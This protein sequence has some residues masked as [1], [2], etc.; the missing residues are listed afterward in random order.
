[1]LVEYMSKLREW[2]RKEADGQWVLR[3]RIPSRFVL[4]TTAQAI[5]LWRSIVLII[6]AFDLYSSGEFIGLFS[7]FPVLYSRISLFLRDNSGPDWF[8]G[9]NSLSS[10][11]AALL[12][13][14]RPQ[15]LIAHFKRR[16]ARRTQYPLGFFLFHLE[17]KLSK[18]QANSTVF[19]FRFF[20]YLMFPK[21]LSITLHHK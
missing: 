15:L 3:Y 12:I 2:V 8:S 14:T 4:S 9:S 1:M 21:S 5:A 11:S 20:W 10:A 19:D 18:C 16:E 13:G 17:Y 7:F 6:T